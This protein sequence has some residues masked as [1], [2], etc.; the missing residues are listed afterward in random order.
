MA[1]GGRDGLIHLFQLL[2]SDL[3]LAD[4]V[5]DHG[6]HSVTGLVFNQDTTRLISC[7]SDRSF[8]ARSVSNDCALSTYFH[9]QL[10]PLGSQDNTH[11][12]GGAFLD[13]ALDTE[14]R[15]A[16]IASSD[17][18]LRLYDIVEARALGRVALQSASVAVRVVLDA[19]GTIAFCSFMDGSIHSYYLPDGSLIAMSHGGHSGVASSLILAPDLT[20][21]TSVGGDGVMLQWMLP[22]EVR[23]ISQPQ[24]RHDTTPLPDVSKSN[25][26]M[27]NT[28]MRV[29][30]GKPLLSHDKL[31]KWARPTIPS[32]D[33]PQELPPQATSADDD[34]SHEAPTASDPGPGPDLPPQETKK[35][36][37]I[38]RV[39]GLRLKSKKNK[40][41]VKAPAA[42]PSLAPSGG[43]EKDQS[44]KVVGR[45]MSICKME[46]IPEEGPATSEGGGN[47]N[48]SL[49]PLVVGA[50]SESGA[51]RQLW[52]ETLDD[53]QVELSSPLHEPSEFSVKACEDA[54]ME[55]PLVVSVAGSNS[56]SKEEEGEMQYDSVG[57]ASIILPPRDLFK[58]HYL[59]QPE[60]EMGRPSEAA[61]ISMDKVADPRRQSL[62]SNYRQLALSILKDARRKQQAEAMII[63]EEAD[64]AVTLEPEVIDR[65]PVVC[66]QDLP[67]TTPVLRQSSPQRRAGRLEADLARMRERLQSLNKKWDKQ[68]KKAEKPT[69]AELH[70]DPVPAPALGASSLDVVN[71]LPTTCGLSPADAEAVH[72]PTIA[73]LVIQGQEPQHQEQQLQDNPMFNSSTPLSTYS[74]TPPPKDGLIFPFGEPQ[75]SPAADKMDK[76]DL[77]PRVL[78]ENAAFISVERGGGG[79]GGGGPAPMSPHVSQDRGRPLTSPEQKASVECSPSNF[80]LAKRA[81]VS[82]KLPPFKRS[83]P[84]KT[85]AT[86]SQILPAAPTP[87][88]EHKTRPMQKDADEVDLQL[89]S[90][91][92]ALSGNDLPHP[93]DQDAAPPDGIELSLSLDR[94]H[95]A[96]LETTK[97][98]AGHQSEDNKV[99]LRTIL[100]VLQALT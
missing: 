22:N 56:V 84:L 45:S 53:D 25:D 7:G 20:S 14:G 54:E 16:V 29:K 35:M 77:L 2:G 5:D 90:I 43:A 58:E 52:I 21:L 92:F 91:E 51:Q 11:K 57:E 69:A 62:S 37:F 24:P 18:T 8:I 99:K 36:S 70:P 6:A 38:Q 68:A 83:E 85:T 63:Q 40:A 44:L 47:R 64:G 26:L 49:K 32:S 93:M 33:L 41:I 66:P 10:P 79:G 12:S 46:E 13:L 27:V 30:Q 78:M 59:H 89:E 17:G 50:P 48:S 82:N 80:Q 97:L 73:P 100:S 98:W 9:D 74:L 96:A 3:I 65:L 81:R 23:R 39:L 67:V 87:L 71:H 19:S 94:L 31:P 60:P 55:E 75:S 88:T 42:E 72:P 28:L 4:T 61:S 86:E 34:V 76:G 95:L 15:L 1:S